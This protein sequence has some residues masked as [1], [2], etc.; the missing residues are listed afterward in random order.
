M[1]QKG[2]GPQGANLRHK[3]P[4]GATLALKFVNHFKPFF[5]FKSPLSHLFLCN[6]SSL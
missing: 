1:T 3:V 4:H 6:L 2:N 5:G